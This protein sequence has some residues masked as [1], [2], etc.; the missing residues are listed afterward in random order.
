MYRPILRR[1]VIN[2]IIALVTVV[3]FII[4]G[5]YHVGISA[6]LRKVS[7][8]NFISSYIKPLTGSTIRIDY[9]TI[10]VEFQRAM[11]DVE[12]R[13]YMDLL[14]TLDHVTRANNITMFMNYGTLLGSVRYHAFLPWDNDC[15]VGIPIK[16][17]VYSE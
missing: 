17:K 16:S 15:D 4:T 7:Y 10:P 3:L 1:R 8:H 13:D 6:A 12:T 9:S 14:Q 5:F 11:T 2:Y